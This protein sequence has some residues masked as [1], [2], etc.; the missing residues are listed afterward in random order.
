MTQRKSCVPR[1]THACLHVCARACVCTRLSVCT[2][3]C[4]YLYIISVFLCVCASVWNLHSNIGM[5]VISRTTM[6]REWRGQ[7]TLLMSP[8]L[9]K[10]RQWV[11][12]SCWGRKQPVVQMGTT[13]IDRF[14]LLEGGGA[15]N[16]CM[17]S[18]LW[19]TMVSMSLA[20]RCLAPAAESF[21]RVPPVQ[22]A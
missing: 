3:V 9:V 21:M 1:A 16:A 10:S 13:S 14:S 18:E 19:R 17:Q 4:M 5:C 15:I 11:H 6:M 12:V 20:C 22:P 8:E 2:F 7:N